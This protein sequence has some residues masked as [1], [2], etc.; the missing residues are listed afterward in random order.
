M[1]NEAVRHVLGGKAEAY[2]VFSE[3]GYG[4]DVLGAAG[5]HPPDGLQ[6]QL[7]DIAPAAKRPK[8][9]SS[10][11]GVSRDTTASTPANKKK[12]AAKGSSVTAEKSK[13][14]DDFSSSEE[15]YN[16]DDLDLEKKNDEGGGDLLEEKIPEGAE[17]EKG[18]AV[19]DVVVK[20][21]GPGDV[22]WAQDPKLI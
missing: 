22:A 20:K 14:M 5:L 18:G 12:Q 3:A 17:G 10:P 15:E 4:D 11:A 13:K 2:L 21:K 1:F 19:M 8:I 16:L 6:P 7:Q 9:D